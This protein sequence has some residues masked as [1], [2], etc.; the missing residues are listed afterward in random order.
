[1]RERW[2][3]SYKNKGILI[4]KNKLSLKIPAIAYR[5]SALNGANSVS[6]N[7]D[8]RV[9]SATSL[10]CKSSNRTNITVQ[11]AKVDISLIG[12][13]LLKVGQCP[14]LL[15]DYFVYLKRLK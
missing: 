6:T 8:S 7:P 5:R 14:S 12:K 2:N 13:A 3:L 9:C 4:F 15:C 11:A 10:A 1:M